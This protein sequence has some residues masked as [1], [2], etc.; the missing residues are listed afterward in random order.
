MFLHEK[1]IKHYIS[2]YSFCH[3]SPLGFS[4]LYKLLTIL[5]QVHMFV[6]AACQTHYIIWCKL[7]TLFICNAGRFI[8]IPVYY[9]R[10]SF[11]HPPSTWALTNLQQKALQFS[12]FQCF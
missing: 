12:I 11:I 4:S 10:F 3:I 2:S 6:I 1:F 7:F 8:M 9:K 5:L